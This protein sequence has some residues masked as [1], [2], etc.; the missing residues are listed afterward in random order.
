MTSSNVTSSFLILYKPLHPSKFLIT[1]FNENFLNIFC[2]AHAHYCHLHVG[3][4][5]KVSSPH[6]DCN[7]DQGLSWMRQS[8]KIII[9]FFKC[10]RDR[11]RL[12]LF[13]ADLVLAVDTHC[14]SR[15]QELNYTCLL[16]NIQQLYGNQGEN[17]QKYYHVYLLFRIKLTL[18]KC[19]QKRIFFESYCSIFGI[20][21]GE[22]VLHF[23]GN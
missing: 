6:V 7:K 17:N 11:E 9:V 1:V 14:V 4:I 21:T 18:P 22:I 2:H 15:R 5:Q 20:F 16:R 12:K 13:I 19:A 10:K 3:Q 23:K 8:K